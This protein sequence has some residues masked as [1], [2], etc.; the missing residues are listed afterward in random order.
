MYSR[1][2]REYSIKEQERVIKDQEKEA[3]LLL[4]KS[5]K[6]MSSIVLIIIILLSTIVIVLFYLMQLKINQNT[7]EV[8]MSQTLLRTQM[9][10]H[11][12]FNAM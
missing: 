8:D 3:E 12:I 9:N 7:K 10:P 2:L 4:L 5:E 1:E 6:Q 11:F